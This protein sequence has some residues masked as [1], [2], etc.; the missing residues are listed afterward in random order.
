MGITDHRARQHL[1]AAGQRYPGVWRKMDALRQGH[2]NG[3]PAWPPWCYLPLMTFHSALVSAGGSNHTTLDLLTDVTRLAALA[4]W[5]PTQ[6]IYRFDPT[7]YEALIETPLTGDLPCELLHRLPEWCVYCETPG[8]AW[9]GA[10]LHGFFAHLQWDPND[11]SEELRLLLDGDA[12][13]ASLPIHLGPWS[14]MEAVTRAVNEMQRAVV[15]L[16]AVMPSD[17]AAQMRVTAEPL[18]SLL[19][20]LCADEADFGAARPA[21]PRPKRTKLGW[22]LFPADKPLAWDIGVRL[23]AALRRAYR[24]PETDPP[25]VDPATGRLRPRAHIRRAHWHRFRVG[26][27][28]AQLRLRWLPPIAVN[29]EEAGALPAS[30]RSVE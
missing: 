6:G 11:G 5:R 21:H 30:V 16:G 18:L 29:L 27:G 8:R 28:R 17:T 14:L 20:Y 3:M 10:P 26:E 13:L 24:Q 12:A 9:R 19:L 7:L 2:G 1:I 23:G 25:E 15:T 22:R 4:A